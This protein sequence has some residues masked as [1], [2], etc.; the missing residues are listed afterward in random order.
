MSMILIIMVLLLVII[1]CG[2]VVFFIKN[3]ILTQKLHHTAMQLKA[4][5]QDASNANKAKSSFLA[6]MSHEIR[7]PMNV[8]LG[9][10][11][12]ELQDESISSDIGEAFGK[13]YESGDLLLNIIND[14]LDLS[15]IEAGKLKIIPFKYDIPS[16]IND[17]VQLNRLRFSSK[18]ID[19]S[20]HV[21]EN[22]PNY[23]FGDELRIRQVLN[24]ILS[25]AF[26]YTD[27]GMVSLN[28]CAESIQDDSENVMLVIR[29]RDTGHGMTAE[30]LKELFNEYTRFNT[31]ANRETIGTGL[32]MSITKQLLDLMKGEIT[33]KSEPGEGSEFVV[34]I[35]QKTAG[36]EICGSEAVEKLKSFNFRSTTLSNKMQFIRE[37]MPYGNVLVV[38]D[39]ESNIYVIKGM[40]LPYGI[41]VDVASSGFDAIKKI[42]EGN[43]YDI[44]FMDHMMPKMDG[45]ETTKRLRDMGYK[46]TIVALTANAIIGCAEMFMS[47]GFDGYISKPIDSRE[48]N[49]MLNDLIRN[50]KSPEV[51]EAVRYFS[52]KPKNG[53]S[54]AKKASAMENEMTAAAVLDVENAIAVLEEILPDIKNGNKDLSLYTTT[55]HGLK[56]AL[57]NIGE[58]QLSEA[59]F[60]L[61]KASANNGEITE[62]LSETHEFIDTLRL[63]LK[64]IK[65]AKKDEKTELSHVEI[66]FLLDKLDAVKTAC[67]KYI[68]SDAKKA[69]ADLKQKTWPYELN[70]ILNKISLHIIRGEFTNVESAADMAINMFNTDKGKK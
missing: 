20:I 41:N 40:L 65:T 52:L 13:I 45:I 43:I 48:L 1:I 49:L 64:K 12:I 19:F 37:Y 44:V 6:N 69:L 25:N 46:D 57:A 27:E 29:I 34:R 5:A 31:E 21:D 4:A 38:D 55:V 15:K 24:N 22:M 26:K 23:L 42:K 8:I 9:I 28:V 33:V 60:G 2:L 56:S 18:P 61:E 58:K 54:S 63:F 70:E 11:E 10:A 66:I 67:K 59:A 53:K 51:I 16:L 50:K 68:I 35:P 14:L 30:Q 36:T 3:R 17:S 32:G 39:V 7:T 62:I 47:N